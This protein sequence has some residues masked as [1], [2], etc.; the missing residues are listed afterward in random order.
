MTLATTLET[1]GENRHCLRLEGRVDSLTATQLEQA[2]L[3]LWDGT[4]ARVLVDFQTLDYISSAGLRIILMAAK[5]ALRGRGR[6]LLCA[7]QPRVAE[8]FEMSGFLK[9][10]DV[11]ATRELG[12]AQLAEAV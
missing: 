9:I 4:E 2:L 3:G 12:L 11:A 1:L 7:L 10:L 5:R 6:L 8:V